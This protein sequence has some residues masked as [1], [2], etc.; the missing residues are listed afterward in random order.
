[1]FPKSIKDKY[2]IYLNLEKGL[3][4]NTLEAYLHDLDILQNFIVEQNIDYK[5]ITLENLQNLLKEIAEL[6]INERSRA[7]MISGWKIFFK[8]CVIE[9]LLQN[10]PSE[11]LEMPK[12][13]LYLPEVLSVEEIEK[14]L[15]AIDLSLKEG[16][17]NVAIIETLYGSGLRV[18]ELI[19]IRLSNIYF[20][21]KF[22]KVIGK[23]DKQRLVPLSDNTIKAI[24][25]WLRE[26]NLMKIKPKQEDFLFLNRRGAQLTREMIFIIIKNAA[27][28]AEITKKISPHTLRHSFATHLLEGGANLRA[29]QQLLGHSS[30]TTTEIYTHINIDFLR[31][32]IIFHHPRN[33][34]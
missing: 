7:R 21:E 3:S 1:V 16:H 33:Q 13:P 6:G 20:E 34:R 10:D 32:E 4:E 25:L 11:L 24:S 2:S 15:A 28:D 23:G 14:M 26:R 12:L 5:E 27:K 8:F 18:S 29:I 22:M 19:N 30:I 31:E 9:K 17:R